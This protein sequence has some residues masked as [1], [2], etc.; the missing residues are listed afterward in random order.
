MRNFIVLVFVTLMGCSLHTRQPVFNIRSADVVTASA[1]PL[2]KSRLSPSTNAPDFKAQIH[3]AFQED[4]ARRFNHFL[5]KHAGQNYELQV[6]GEVL[7]RS[8]G[9]YPAGGREVWWYTISMEQ[10]QHFA[11]SLNRK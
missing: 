8:V 6:N 5:E 11:T 7:L 10:A 4:G 3:I 2:D 9:A 1:E